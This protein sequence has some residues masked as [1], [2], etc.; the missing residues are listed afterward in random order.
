MFEDVPFV[1][2]K[3]SGNIDRDPSVVIERRMVALLGYPCDIYANGR[4]VRSQTVALVTSAAKAGIPANW[5]GAFSL[6]PLPNLLGDGEMY[7]IDLRTAA[8]IDVMYLP[9]HKRLRSFSEYG[10]SVFKQR[11]I[12]TDTRAIVSDISLQRIG[13]AAWDEM[14]LWQEWNETGADPEQFQAW[15]DTPDVHLSGLTR[16]K[17]LERG[18][19]EQVRGLM[20]MSLPTT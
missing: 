20:R 10:W 19:T 11:L 12:L 3:S 1:K 7:A 13:G 5:D 9:T 8:N 16:R 18:G 14:V 2:A 4:P 6:A 17:I 15:L